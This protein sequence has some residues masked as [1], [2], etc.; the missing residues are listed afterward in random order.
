MRTMYIESGVD[1]KGKSFSVV[2]YDC[3]YGPMKGYEI[4]LTHDAE[5]KAM[6][7]EL[8]SHV[9]PKEVFDNAVLFDAQTDQVIENP[10]DEKYRNPETGLIQGA[11]FGGTSN[12]VNLIANNRLASALIESANNLVIRSYFNGHDETDYK[13]VVDRTLESSSRQK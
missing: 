10:M 11:Y 1:A 12:S 2:S 7:V 3:G 9:D 4:A 13:V 8:A 6:A 5:T